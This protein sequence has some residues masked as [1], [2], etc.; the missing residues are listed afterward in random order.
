MKSEHEG[1]PA[2][3]CKS[4]WSVREAC[5]IDRW[6]MG[7]DWKRVKT[8][9]PGKGILTYIAVNNNTEIENAKIWRDERVTMYRTHKYLNII[10][11]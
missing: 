10:R 7:D 2:F 1:T 9:K 4:T 3:P 5:K 8:Q 6:I 11:K